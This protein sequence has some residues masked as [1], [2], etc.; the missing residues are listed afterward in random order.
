MAT[1]SAR[2]QFRLVLIKPSHYD[3]DGYVIQWFRNIIPSNSLACLCAIASAAGERRI[4][5]DDVQIVVH[6][7]DEADNCNRSKI[8]CDLVQIQRPDYGCGTISFDGVPIRVDGRFVP[9]ELRALDP[10]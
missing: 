9:E 2:R 6:A 8:H 5:G 1:I 4:L 7:Y 10:E 3:D